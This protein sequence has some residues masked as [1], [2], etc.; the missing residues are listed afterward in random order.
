MGANLT[1]EKGSFAAEAQPREKLSSNERYKQKR[2]FRGKKDTFV[3]R[4]NLPEI[5]DFGSLQFTRESRFG[6]NF[7]KF[8]AS[9]GCEL[10]IRCGG[11][12]QCE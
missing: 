1:A 9:S 11:G 4:T 10:R 3:K 5:D 8:T 12:S 7:R 6:R 2:Y